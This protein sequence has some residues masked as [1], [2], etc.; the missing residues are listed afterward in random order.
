MA[1]GRWTAATLQTHFIATCRPLRRASARVCRLLESRMPN[2]AWRFWAS[3]QIRP[4]ELSILWTPSR[5]FA[6][7]ATFSK[8]PLL[9]RTSG[10]VCT[11]RP[12]LYSASQRQRSPFLG[13]KPTQRQRMRWASPTQSGG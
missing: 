7:Y 12:C 1:L 13:R 6:S 9:R 4:A 10:C 2:A 8:T 11:L 5:W 3:S